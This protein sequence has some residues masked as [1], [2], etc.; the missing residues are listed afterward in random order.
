MILC[1]S[2]IQ[3]YCKALK[4]N[5]YQAMISLF[6]KDAKVFSYLA[7]DQPATEFYKNLFGTSRRTSVVVK[8]MFIESEGKTT[9]AVYL[10]LEAIRYEKFAIQFEAVDIFEFDFENKITTL[11][12]IMDTWPLRK[13]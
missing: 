10:Y 13:L 6:A 1:K 5:D 8:N 2:I 3:S 4:E 7:G 9:V 12:I 11:K